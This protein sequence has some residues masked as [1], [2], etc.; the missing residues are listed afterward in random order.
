MRCDFASRGTS[1]GMEGLDWLDSSFEET[2][3]T[4]SFSIHARQLKDG[5]VEVHINSG[6]ISG[7]GKQPR[8]ALTALVFTQEGYRLLMAL[9]HSV[10]PADRRNTPKDLRVPQAI[11]TRITT[12]PK[13][14][15]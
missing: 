1:C 15:A 6:R 2:R 4:E 14:V 7:L 9:L 12:T 3:G 10:D 8:I 13:G 11:D 5:Q